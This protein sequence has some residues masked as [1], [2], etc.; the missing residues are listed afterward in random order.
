MQLIMAVNGSRRQSNGSRRQYYAVIDGNRRQFVFFCLKTCVY[1]KKSSIFA[2]KL[3]MMKRFGILVICIF[4]AV[5]IWGQEKVVAKE[6]FKEAGYSIHKRGGSY[7]TLHYLGT[8]S[9]H[10]DAVE[11]V[12][13]DKKPAISTGTR[14]ITT[15]LR[16]SALERDSVYDRGAFFIGECKPCAKEYG[17]GYYVIGSGSVLTVLR[18][19]KG[20]IENREWE[21]KEYIRYRISLAFFNALR[22]IMDETITYKEGKIILAEYESCWDYFNK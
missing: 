17:D 18:N 11:L 13:V 14:E 8:D 16:W 12:F 22:S 1:Q 15:V 2:P 7:C 21:K 20:E 6:I 4:L 10:I 19:E 3:R 9:D 5:L